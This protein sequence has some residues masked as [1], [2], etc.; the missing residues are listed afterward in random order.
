M[1]RVLPR[2]VRWNVSRPALPFNRGPVRF[3]LNVRKENIMS[4]VAPKPPTAE[5]NTDTEF[6]E[7]VARPTSGTAPNY[8]VDPKALLEPIAGLT[9]YDPVEMAAMSDYLNK[10]RG[11]FKRYGFT[12]I[13]S[14]PFEYAQHL[15]KKG[16]ITKQIYGVSRL[17]DGSLTNLGI[18]FDHT[19]PTAIFVAKKL[20][21]ATVGKPLVFPYKRAAIGYS[22]RGE[23]AIAGKGRYRAFIQCDAD[24]FGKKLTAGSDAETLT[25][26]I[27][28]LQALGVENSRVCL[29]HVDIARAFVSEAGVPDDKVDDALR[30]IDKLKPDNRQDVIDELVQ[31]I[32]MT[33]GQADQLMKDIDYEGPLSEYR[34][35]KPPSPKTLAAFE[36]LREIERTCEGM[37]VKKGTL[38]FSTKLTRGLDYY[39]GVVAETFIEGQEKYGSIAS[40]GRYDDLVDGLGQVGQKVQGVGFSI[41]LTRLF[42]ALQALNLVDLSRQTVAEVF[43]GYRTKGEGCYEKALEVATELRNMGL[44]VEL[45][46]EEDVKVKTELDLC[47]RKGIPCSVMVMRTD[48]IQVANM[49]TGEKTLFANVSDV[50]KRVQELR[51]AGVLKFNPSRNKDKDDSK[52]N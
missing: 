27:Q 45:Y 22:C 32:S 38:Y 5:L 11:V 2:L 51:K 15:Q 7:F 43:V 18:P 8:A 41:G 52:E 16:G 19:V 37:G 33:R 20:K 48:D 14:P 35:A 40:G 21:G 25:A 24:I 17:Q 4:A 39:T 12:G 31:K 44:S 29:N 46:T 3:L 34:F 30:V 6:G 23:R 47:N 26:I 28:G 42:D 9:D 36:H 13:V 49:T 1:L 50:M 10:I